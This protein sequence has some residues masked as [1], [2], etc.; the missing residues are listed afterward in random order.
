MGIQTKE[1]TDQEKILARI[2]LIVK[3]LSYV[4]GDLEK[5]I[6]GYANATRRAAGEWENFKAKFGTP[7]AGFAADAMAGARQI[8]DNPMGYVKKLFTPDSG[9]AFQKEADKRAGVN[10]KEMTARTP[11]AQSKAERDAEIMAGIY[12]QRAAADREREIDKPGRNLMANLAQGGEGL[13]QAL[14]NALSGNVGN[15]LGGFLK[16]GL[17]GAVKERRRA[18][19]SIR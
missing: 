8:A 9:D 6:G 17:G 5:T 1:L 19:C 16:G 13:K 18:A 11:N 10:S 7:V 4:Q 14:G 12:K 15:I 3:G 2:A